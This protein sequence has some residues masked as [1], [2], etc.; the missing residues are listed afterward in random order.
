[1]H[2]WLLVMLDDCLHLLWTRLLHDRHYLQHM[3]I[4]LQDLLERHGLHGLLIRLPLIQ[5]NLRELRQQL[6]RLRYN[7]HLHEVC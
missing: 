3:S 5:W 7:E 4:R 1:M 2:H 6:R